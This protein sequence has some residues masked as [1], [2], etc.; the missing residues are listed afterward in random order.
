VAV[1]F[2][3]TQLGPD[4][5]SVLKP[6]DVVRLNHPGSA[7]LD[8]TVEDT[9]FAHATAGAQGQRLAA[10]IVGTRKEN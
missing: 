1:R 8:V 9:V 6:G 2:R 4:A 5:L 7:P 10:L 3:S